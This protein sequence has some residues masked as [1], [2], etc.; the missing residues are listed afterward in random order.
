MKKTVTVLGVFAFAVALTAPLFAAEQ[1]AAATDTEIVF[2]PG[3]AC[4]ELPA[5]I[6]SRSVSCDQVSFGKKSYAKVKVG[7]APFEAGAIAH[8]PCLAAEALGLGA[9]G[10][11]AFYDDEVH[12]HLNLVP[13]EGQVVYHFAI[14]YPV[15]G[16]RYLA[17]LFGGAMSGLAGGYLSLAITPMWVEGMTAGRRYFRRTSGGEIPGRRHGGLISHEQ[18]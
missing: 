16:I 18:G 4:N 9:T 12:R 15:I 1:K 5:D 2:V 14:G 7:Y 6:Q 8:C 17:V 11:G 10:I 3:R 13:S